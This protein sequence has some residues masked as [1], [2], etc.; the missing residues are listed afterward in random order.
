MWSL[1]VCALARGEMLI[2]VGAFQTSGRLC[3]SHVWKTIDKVQELYSLRF[4]TVG[5]NQ[6][7]FIRLREYAN[8]SAQGRFPSGFKTEHSLIDLPSNSRLLV[9]PK[10]SV[11]NGRTLF[12]RVSG[13]QRLFI[14]WL[15]LQASSW[16]FLSLCISCVRDLHNELIQGSSFL[17][18]NASS[19][20]RTSLFSWPMCLL[21]TT[22]VKTFISVPSLLI[23]SAIT[24][25]I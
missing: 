21:F 18:F 5:G 25:A 10:T 7:A 23:V 13:A 12:A 20:V 17:L 14:C 9:S 3:Y 4:W 8:A 6:S 11:I 22:S 15:A 1:H 19:F 16:L 2:K 24:N